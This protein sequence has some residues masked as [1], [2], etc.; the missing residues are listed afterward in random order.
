M[1]NKIAGSKESTLN[2]GNIQFIYHKYYSPQ[3]TTEEII[4]S[5]SCFMHTLAQNKGFYVA[6]PDKNTKIFAIE[7]IPAVNEFPFIAQ[8]NNCAYTDKYIL[9]GIDIKKQA[10]FKPVF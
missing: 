10:F 3:N 5:Q 4:T 7:F 1:R 6:E 2:I 9:L 8:I